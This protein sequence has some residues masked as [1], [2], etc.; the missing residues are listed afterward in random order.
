[1]R[2]DSWHSVQEQQG[3]MAGSEGMPACYLRATPVTSFAVLA[4]CLTSRQK[5]LDSILAESKVE[6][7]L[8]K[9]GGS[10]AQPH[11]DCVGEG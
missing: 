3:V 1:M 9:V 2:T 6:L 8:P 5:F 4:V 7:Y 10:V 11:N